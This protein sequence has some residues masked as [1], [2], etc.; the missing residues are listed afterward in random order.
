LF[1]AK[2][3]LSRPPPIIAAKSGIFFARRIS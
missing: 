3:L 2:H 1:K